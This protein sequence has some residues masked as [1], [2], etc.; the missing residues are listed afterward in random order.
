[1]IAALDNEARFFHRTLALIPFFMLMTLFR[2]VA[3]NML[4]RASAVGFVC[5]RNL[6]WTRLG[7][8]CARYLSYWEK[9]RQRGLDL[10][11]G[12]KWDSAY[13][14]LGV[15]GMVVRAVSA[16]SLEP[17]EAFRA[18]LDNGL[19]ANALLSSGGVCGRIDMPM[20][21]AVLSKALSISASEALSARCR[22]SER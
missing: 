21:S 8:T 17:V 6:G 22:T 13:G 16:V 2:V 14:M 20:A 4:G 9:V 18:W 19:S 1:M 3:P 5:L 10:G 15:E 7:S 11:L 12:G